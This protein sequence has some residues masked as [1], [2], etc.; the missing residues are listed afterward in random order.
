M[1]T[2]QG[3]PKHHFLSFFLICYPAA[4]LIFKKYLYYPTGV[5][6]FTQ[7]DK[8]LPRAKPKAALQTV[9]GVGK[10]WPAGL[11]RGER[12]PHFYCR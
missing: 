12:F 4:R 6:L 3:I 11:A 10:D 7:T 9:P 2:F 1:Q 5:N 8:C